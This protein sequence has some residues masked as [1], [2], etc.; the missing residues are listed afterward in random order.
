MP[1]IHRYLAEN[2]DRITGV[3]VSD[4]FGDDRSDRALPVRH[5][6]KR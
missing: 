6:L 5:M 2:A 1:D 3:H 4:W